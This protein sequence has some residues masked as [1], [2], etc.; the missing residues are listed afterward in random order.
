M[1]QP[2]PDGAVPPGSRHRAGSDP[3]VPAWEAEADRQRLQLALKA[4]SVFTWEM[5]LSTGQ[6]T[7]SPNVADILG[8]SPGTTDNSATELVHPADRPGVMRRF[9]RGLTGEEPF[10]AEF[11]LVHPYTAEI[12]WIRS[13]GRCIT[14]GGVPDRFIGVAQDITEGKRRDLHAAFLAEVQRDLANL[15]D[16]DATLRAI[17]E[18]VARSFDL[19][20]LTFAEIDGDEVTVIY[21][22]HHEDGQTTVDPHRDETLPGETFIHDLRAGRTITIEDVRTDPRV[23]SGGAPF[24]AGGMRSAILSP[25]LSGGRLKFLLGGHRLEPHSWRKDEIETLRDLAARLYLRLER[26]HADEAHRASEA[27]YRTLFESIDEG[28][29]VVEMLFDD[30]GA[31]VDYRFLDVNPAFERQTGLHEAAGKRMREIAPMHEEHWFEIYGQV[32][33]SDEPASFVQKATALGARWF[34]VHAFR[35]GD[36]ASR[37]VAMIF[38]DITER[39]RADD[40]LRE[41]EARLRHAL[42][43][44]TVGVFFFRAEGAITHANNAFLRMSGYTAEDVANGQVRWDMMTPPEWMPRSQ[45]AIDEFVTTGRISPYEKE[46]LRRDGSRWW[47]LLTATRLDDHGGVSFVIDITGSKLATA[48]QAWLAAMVESSR[49]AVIGTDINGTITSWNPAATRLYGYRPE[50]A[51]GRSISILIPPDRADEREHLFD[52]LRQGED[53]SPLETERL[54]KDGSRVDVD[55]RSSL[56]RDA[57]GRFAGV[58]VVTN[59][60]TERRRLERAQEDFLTMASHDLRSP[61]TVLRGRAQLMKRHQKYDEVALNVMLDQTRRIERLTEDLQELVRLEAGKVDLHLTKVDLRELVADAAD[62]PRIQR[63]SHRVRV[64]MPPVAVTGEWD[65]DRIGQILDNLLANAAKYSDQESDIVVEVST[66]GQD[67]R[68]NITDRGSGIAADALPR[69]FDR[70]YRVDETGAASGLGLGLYISRMLVEAH[71]GRVWVESELGE[72]STFRVAFP[73]EQVAH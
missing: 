8:F 18:R 57:A 45:Q 39:K 6:L 37:N 69:L 70:F 55:L 58:A 16:I 9:R 24:D 72:G 14:G 56:I 12:V 17:G 1:D 30:D 21:R 67:A 5:D 50:E 13:Q 61:V 64:I 3:P 54:R 34:D 40:A 68:V 46:Y 20:L 15:A 60:V 28:F 36:P 33:M 52:Q 62:R 11:R 38:T 31:P 29:C 48:E 32:A 10:E 23:S 66:T 7:C 19:A 51:V 41:S 63:T 53:P 65:R 71:G 42:E 59:D 26:A 22:Q 4:G 43:I 49:D 25:H 2:K 27:R 73:L 35:L 47:V 44:E